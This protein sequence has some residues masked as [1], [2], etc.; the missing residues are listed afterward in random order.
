MRYLAFLSTLQRSEGQLPGNRG[1]KGFE[2]VGRGTVG[3][4]ADAVILAN[5]KA[6]S[7]LAPVPEVGSGRGASFWG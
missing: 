5:Y 2:L 6:F 1:S 3:A 4:A 7:V